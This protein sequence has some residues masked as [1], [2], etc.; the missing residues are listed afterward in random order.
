MKLGIWALLL[1]CFAATAVFAARRF[2]D[3]SCVFGNCT[4]AGAAPDT[5]GG[6]WGIVAAG[7]G[8]GGLVALI[9]ASITVIRG[10]S[11]SE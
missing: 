11:K 3:G 8:L 9:G 4:E 10:S 5:A 2:L 6:G 1:A 7:A